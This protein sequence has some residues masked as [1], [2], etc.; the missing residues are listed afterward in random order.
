MK[1]LKLSTSSERYFVFYWELD[2]HVFGYG[3]NVQKIT[4]D[5]L[6]WAINT[7][8]GKNKRECDARKCTLIRAGNWIHDVIPNVLLVVVLYPF[9]VYDSMF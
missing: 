5:S 9:Y 2:V 1:S 7:L 8:E 4:P 3:V 6:F